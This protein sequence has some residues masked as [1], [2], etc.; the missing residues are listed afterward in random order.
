MRYTVLLI[1][2]ASSSQLDIASILELAHYNV[3]KADSGKSGVKMAIALTPDIILC[4]ADMPGL[5]GFVVLSIIQ[6]KDTLKHIP[7]I[8]LT[9]G[10]NRKDIRRGMIMGADDFI[11]TPFDHTEILLVVETRLLKLARRW[12]LPIF[13][14]QQLYE[15]FW[16]G[17]S[18]HVYKEKEVL[19]RQGQLALHVFYVIDGKLKAYQLGD[20]GKTLVTRLYGAHEFIGYTAIFG[21]SLYMENIVVLENARIVMIPLRKVE[22]LSVLHS[23]ILFTFGRLLS[24][25]L[26]EREMQMISLAYHSLRK[27]VATALLTAYRKYNPGRKRRQSMV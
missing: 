4:S 6:R 24:N 1:M 22:E 10:F 20:E 11:S 26:V 25:D 23:E 13:N 21:R 17:L 18:I 3:L 19:C 9:T 16:K 8:L 7:F 2:P 15:K 12:Q 27:R 14:S 5:D